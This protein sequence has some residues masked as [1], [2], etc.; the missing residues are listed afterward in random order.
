[1]DAQMDERALMARPVAEIGRLRTRSLVV[2]VIGLALMA[3]GYVTARDT[4]LQS[5]LIGFYFWM[6]I[7][8]GSLAVLM[9]QYLSGGVWGLVG[10][11]IFE[12]ST[13]NIWLMALLFVPIGLNLPVLYEWARPEAAH[14]AAIQT[15]AAY[16]NPTFFNIRAIAFFAICILY[17]HACGRL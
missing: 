5:Y 1:M 10:R 2:G 4:F 17:T 6:A 8:L 16:L 13:R 11:R 7:T 3:V 15:K 12:A 14:N 9:V